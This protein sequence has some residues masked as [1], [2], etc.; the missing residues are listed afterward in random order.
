MLLLAV[1]LLQHQSSSITE[2]H[3][4]AVQ[5]QGAGCHNMRYTGRPK[6]ATFHHCG[7]HNDWN[8][9]CPGTRRCCVHSDRKIAPTR[10]TMAL[11]SFESKPGFAQNNLHHRS[12]IQGLWTPICL[13]LQQ[14]QDV[15]LLELVRLVA[16]LAAHLDLALRA[17]DVTYLVRNQQERYRCHQVRPARCKRGD[18]DAICYG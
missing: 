6:T 11:K 7:Q 2:K 17:H 4:H 16:E 10:T 12:R 8:S 5:F 13:M 14:L 3:P 1:I 9:S 18:S 15:L